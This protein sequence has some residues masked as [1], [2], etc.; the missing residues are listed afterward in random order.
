M[1]FEQHVKQCVVVNIEQN[2]DLQVN[3]VGDDLA[4]KETY[5]DDSRYHMSQSP[6]QSLLDDGMEPPWKIQTTRNCSKEGNHPYW[7]QVAA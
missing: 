7:D 2:D 5:M 6:T 3:V 1:K 4:A